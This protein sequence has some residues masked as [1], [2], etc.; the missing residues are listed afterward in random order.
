MTRRTLFSLLATAGAAGAQKFLP[1]IPN[2]GVKADSGPIRSESGV[3]AL[4]PWADALWAV[5]YNS[6]TYRTGTGLG[7]YRIDDQLDIQMVHTSDGTHANRY[8][9]SASNQVFIGPYAIDMKGQW[10]FIEALKNDRLTATMTHLTD[11]DNR[12]YMLSME[13]LLYELDVS[14]LKPTL[15]LDLNKQFGIKRP[16]FK[17]GCTAQGR[18]VVANNGF[19]EFGDLQ[20]GL[21]E[22]DGKNWRPLSRKPHMDCAARN[23]MGQV[24]YSTGWDES[25][26]LFWA[27]VKG[28]WKRYRLPKASHTFDHAWQTEWTRIREVETERFLV[29]VHGMF[30]ELQ[31]IAFQDAVWGVNPIC[32]HL[33]IIPDYCSF[34]GLLAM[35]GNQNTPNRDNNPLGGQPQSGIWFGKTDDLWQFG[36]PKGWGGPWRAATLK[37]GEA[38][39]PFLMTGFDKKVLHLK[40]DKQSLVRIE[41]DFLGMGSWE[42]YEKLAVPS[43]KYHV[44]PAGFSA[45]WVR[46]VAETQCTATAEFIY[47]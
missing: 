43:Y 6:H 47:T 29:D 9:H 42:T 45:H 21:F 13:G 31:P 39:D 37:A 22:W 44:F 4:M 36:K 26:V 17:G 11:P 19:Y 8:V 34:R 46:L 3:G 12:V 33:R 15:L 27:L 7:L 35:A 2:L 32:A 20:A 28:Q 16:H 24:L 41:T 30:Y 25:S 14:T 18:V 23:D 38:S 10:R 5:T 1:G 40:T